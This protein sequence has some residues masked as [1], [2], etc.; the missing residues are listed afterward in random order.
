MSLDELLPQMPL[1]LRTDVTVT[2]WLGNAQ[3]QPASNLCV[4]VL[5]WDGEE[6]SL[7]ELCES[8]LSVTGILGSCSTFPGSQG[9]VRTGACTQTVPCCNNNSA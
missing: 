2:N 6:T 8:Q 7:S 9:A 4:A 1:P 3:S 5:W